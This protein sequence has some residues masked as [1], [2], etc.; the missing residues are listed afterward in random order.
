MKFSKARCWVLHV[1]HNNPMQH[2]RHGE[3]WLEGCLAGKDPG[4]LVKH[5][6]N[7]GVAMG[8]REVIVPLYLALVKP[9]LKHWVQFW[10][11]PS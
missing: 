11:P 8:T 5:P 6:G 2:Y 1:G 4:V 10:A 7:S 9:H 3:K